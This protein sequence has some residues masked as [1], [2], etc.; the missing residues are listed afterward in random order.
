MKTLFNTSFSW[1]F[2]LGTAVVMRIMF[3][4][5]NW[6]SYFALLLSLHQFMLLFNSIGHVIPIR[7]LFG[8]FMCMQFFI[9]PTLAYNGL[10]QYQYIHYKMKIPEGEYFTYAIP[11]VL[12]FITG[13]HL[14][15]GKL[16]GEIIDEEKIKVFVRGHLQLP[17]WFM[18]IG[19]IAS[20]V[21]SFFGSDLAFVFYLLG[22]FKFIGLF[23]LIIGSNELKILPLTVVIGS[24]VG[25]S[26]NEGMF[27]DLLTWI[28]FIGSVFAIKYK[29]GFNLK[30]IG[31]I[32][33]IFVAVTIQVMKSS[34]RTATGSGR[35]EAGVET[36]SKLYQE[37][38]K[39]K[40]L[41]SFESLAPA[42]VRIN[43]GFIITNIMERV[44]ASEPFSNGE[45][46]YQIFEAGILPRILAPNKLN[47]GDRTIFTKYSGIRLRAGTSMGLSS[48]GDAYIN[49]GMIG[50]CFFMFFLGL[51]YSYILRILYQK[52]EIY[53]VLILFA[54]L[55][56]YYPIRPDCE[57]Q[58][59]LGH[60]FKS[61]FLV[62]V[63]IM[64]FKSTFRV[65]DLQTQPRNLN[66][67][68]SF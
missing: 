22:S 19:F 6:P 10:D 55:I 14:F 17:Y 31:C 43:Q 56:F 15:A 30:L 2:F 21:A 65:N 45:E 40:S 1:P 26:L 48:L 32:L 54:P 20:V 57:L 27:H 63:M 39:D 7:Y 24:I 9:G 3:I 11:A 16:N 33:F 44:P 59:I 35:E 25:S 67:R 42:N 13:L 29:F 62:Y 36:F 64:F 52:S 23:L 47:A 50:G 46:M 4:E 41:F 28:I 18:G 53:P 12:S 49:W 38:N 68:P 5:M 8:A 51:M 66:L 34:Y 37:E 61:C 60:L 58:T